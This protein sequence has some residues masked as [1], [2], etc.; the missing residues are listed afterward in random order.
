MRLFAMRFLLLPTLCLGLVH[1]A[2]AEQAWTEIRSPHFRVL[3]D[4][5]AKDGRMVA[6]EFEQMRHV[7]DVR[8]GNDSI[9]SGAPL[10][11]IA[12][13]D[14]NTFRAL[15]PFLWKAQG[16][17]IAGEFHRGWEKQFAIVR[18]D[19]WQG[20]GKEVVYHEYTHSILHA[21]AH[22]LP[23]WL[24]EG[25]AEFY[26]Y[27]R[28]QNDHI[29][30]G[31]PSER[32]GT[33]QRYPLVPVTTMLDVTAQSPYYHD[34]LKMQI[35]YADA[36]AMVHYMI[37]GPGM[38]HGDKLN[39]FFKLLQDE[40]DQQKAFR[41][42]FGDPAAFDKSF[43]QYLQR[44]TFSAGV[45]PP[46]RGDDPKTFAERK[47]SPAEADYEL[48]CFHIGAHNRVA[49]RALIQQAL[50]LDPQLAGAH[51]ELGFLDFD[52]GND[53]EATKEWQQ[54][55]TLDPTRSRSL[56]ALTM[57]G[58]PIARQ[59]RDQLSS[60]QIA[61][62]HITTLAP[63]FAPVYVEL[64]IIEWRLG[65]MQQA[66]QDAHQAETLEPWRA[67]YHI[68]TGRI[69]LKG[70]QPA[71]AAGYS[72]YVASHWFGP[73]H[74]EA[75]DLWEDVPQASRGEGPPLAMDMPQGTTVARGT[76][77]AVSCDD[78]QGAHHFN[79]T[80]APDKPSGAQPLTFASD[81]RLMIG[82]SDTL[83]WG[84]DHF[85]ACHHLAGHP[86]VVAY[87][88]QGPQGGQLVDLEVHDELPA[89]SQPAIATTQPATA[90]P[91]PA[92]APAHP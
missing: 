4:S 9:E 41:Q 90:K 58:I 38:D 66:Y 28:F 37:F 73:D 33:L 15:E 75:L 59:T 44:F 80:L 13:R 78:S 67:G 52:A 62:R 88:P 92:P 46:D 32:M 20:G 26:S 19:N 68:L 87:R 23:I 74:D 42:V 83:W 43:S 3:T 77:T 89:G 2:H 14:G 11:I 45:L 64:A 63:R 50:T 27:T 69:L 49:G 10:T 12:A 84:E 79:I 57:S 17:K 53:D 18:L 39:A 40:V 35:F 82:F 36:W 1:C 65:Y 81:G 21:N 60:S 56:F 34:D 7:F 22:W 30:I 29:Y 6:N 71:L 72:R 8:F 48:G 25:L 5:S 24:D 86:A 51:E 16:D 76:L 61:L 54:A 70:N 85:S 47:L 31:A 91:D 55:V